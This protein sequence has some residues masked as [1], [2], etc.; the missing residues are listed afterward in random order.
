MGRRIEGEFFWG[1]KGGEGKEVGQE[2]GLDVNPNVESFLNC[3]ED[4]AHLS[5]YQ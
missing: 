4:G 2:Q 3:K 1:G 5:N